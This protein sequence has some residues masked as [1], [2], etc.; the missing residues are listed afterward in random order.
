MLKVWKEKWIQQEAREPESDKADPVTIIILYDCPSP[1][2]SVEHNNLLYKL[3]ALDESESSSK[4]FL[5]SRH[6]FLQLGPCASDLVW[7]RALKDIEAVVPPWFE[8]DDEPSSH[9]IVSR[10]R[11]TVKNWDFTMPNL[12]SS[13]PRCN[14]SPKFLQLF[15][16][17]KSC[18]PHGERFRGIIFVHRRCVAFALTELIRT[19]TEPLGFIRPQTLV[20]TGAV[21][22]EEILRNFSTGA[23]NLLVATKSA[24]DLE[25]PT[26]HIVICFDLFDGDISRAYVQSCARGSDAH[27]VY[28][29]QKG[30]FNQRSLVDP[31]G[32]DFELQTW[33]ASTRT[34]WTVPPASFRLSSTLYRS[35]SEDDEDDDEGDFI[36]DPTTGGRI[37]P[38]DAS[39]VLLRFASCARLDPSDNH[40]ERPQ[41]YV[42]T[43]NLP[44]TVVDAALSRRST[45]YQACSKLMNTGY[46]DPEHFFLPR[47]PKALDERL[48]PPLSDKL[49]G[50]RCYSKKVPEFWTHCET[51][52]T[53]TPLLLYPTVLSAECGTLDL[54]YAP[55]VILTR[56]PLP[57]LSSFK[58]FL[59]AGQAF[60]LDSAQLESLS[61]YT[62]RICRA[63]SNKAFTCS[64]SSWTPPKN[65]MPLMNVVDSIHWELVT[66]AC[67]KWAV[68]LKFGD[69]AEVQTGIRDAVIQD[70]SSEFTRHF[71][72]TEVRSDLTPL[73][74][75]EDSTREAEYENLLDYCKNRQKG[76]GGLQ[77]YKQAIVKVV[78]LQTTVDPLN[79][80]SRS[81]GSVRKTGARY[82]IPELCSKSTIPASTFRTSMLLPSCFKRID[83]LLLV[84]ELNAKLLNHAVSEQYL[85]I[86]LSPPSAGIEYDYERLEIL[87]DAFLKYL[88]SIYVFTDVPTHQKG[89]LHMARQQIINDKTLFLC[90]TSVELGSWIQARQFSNKGWCP[91]NFSIDRLG[92]DFQ[93]D[94]AAVKETN[95]Q[96]D[97]SRSTPSSV[98]ELEP[99]RQWL[100]DK[101]IADVVESVIGA[102]FVTGG[103]ERALSVTKSLNI[104][105]PNVAQFSDFGIKSATFA[106]KI[107][108][109]LEPGSL[110]AVEDIIGYRFRRPQIL[111]EALTHASKKYSTD[112]QSF[113]EKLEF[114]G[115]AI[116]EFS[117][118]IFNQH[119]DL[120]PGGMTMLKGGMVSNA[121]LGA[122]C[123]DSGLAVHLALP[124]WP[125]QSDA[126]REYVAT[127]EEKK[128]AEVRK[129]VPA[130][131][132]NDIEPL[133]PLSSLLE[134]I[135]GAL[136][137]DDDCGVVGV[138]KFFDK[139]LKPFFDHHVT[140]KNI[141]RH[142]NKILGE[143]LQSKG[144]HQ[145]EIVKEEKKYT[146]NCLVLVHDIVLAS[147]IGATAESAVRNASFHALDALAGD[148]GFLTKTCDCRTQR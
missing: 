42:C 92:Q 83:E 81:P 117:E 41:T 9:I 4:Y 25:I 82:L 2:A 105:L 102:A 57:R 141:S 11:D 87:G 40:S 22:Q 93:R 134:S 23:H 36:L 111:A 29:V 49:P 12:D 69:A 51:V 74:K 110:A 107:A 38:H 132:W 14:V 6:V 3:H 62:L 55:I 79:P 130:Q 16:V 76:F 146:V 86:A 75:P 19:L 53:S 71:I 59:L 128:K 48:L 121:A 89:A 67:Q 99:P 85:H 17:L 135:F 97:S 13:S 58:V 28:M 54:A 52:G 15:N 109:E 50:T 66:L 68:P 45:C 131:Y 33:L 77:D 80:A 61:S 20:A 125:E 115:N 137:L 96:S 65:D 140:L 8:P 60:E 108:A 84:K 139:I 31:A 78:Q 122:I 100:G 145:L 35:D 88:S 46:L 5:H 123:A 118:H 73:S 126:V 10:I 120:P 21:N 98:I 70:R 136:F 39:G 37:Y 127:L 27:V 133:E 119:P 64:T 26:A 90:G 142:P 32:L 116:L 148:P 143:L 95:S 47:I 112:F 103:Q 43:I 113:F 72:V 94:E 147:S 30:D 104:S 101:A 34:K 91:R 44:G 1:S 129:D 63:I 114:I 144:C 24:E 56:T 7:R 106:H 138:Q 124:D 18:E